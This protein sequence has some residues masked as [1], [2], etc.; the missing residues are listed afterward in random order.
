MRGV[1]VKA[2]GAV[3]YE[4]SVGESQRCCRA[5]HLLPVKESAAQERNATRS[6]ATRSQD[7]TDYFSSEGLAGGEQPG[8]P[9]D[10][11][12][13]PGTHPDNSGGTVNPVDPTADPQVPAPE[14]E[15]PLVEP[16][17]P[18]AGPVT[19]QTA[20]VETG[21]TCLR[22]SLV[23]AERGFSNTSVAVQ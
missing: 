9:E 18:P 2:L 16:E 23:L 7:D 5:D 10:E 15:Q 19:E 6:H 20:P 12:T 3:Q 8:A 13:S 1:I 21:A 11:V 14:P 17:Q 22:Y 4:V